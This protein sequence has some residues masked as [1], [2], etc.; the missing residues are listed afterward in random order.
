MTLLF[1]DRGNTILDP[2]RVCFTG[3]Q[4]CNVT[5]IIQKCVGDFADFFFFFGK[6]CSIVGLLF[7]W[8]GNLHLLIEKG[9]QLRDRIVWTYMD[10]FKAMCRGKTSQVMLHVACVKLSISLAQPIIDRDAGTVMRA[11]WCGHS[12]C[13]HLIGNGKEIETFAKDLFTLRNA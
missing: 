13:D 12:E 1:Y 2:L 7:P 11:Q 10:C 4:G 6:T 8:T 5:V 3:I 9:G